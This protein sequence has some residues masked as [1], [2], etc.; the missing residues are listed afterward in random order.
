MTLRFSIIIPTRNRAA[1]LDKCL[2]ALNAVDYPHDAF[3]VLVVDD[4]SDSP[5][6]D[7]IE[8]H[9]GA[10]RMH[11]LRTEGVGPATARNLALRRA[12]GEYVV[13]TDDDTQAHAGWLRAYDA[14]AKA[15]PMAGFGG[16][17]VDAPENNLPERTSQMLV[18]FL[19]DYNETTDALR[20]FCSNNLVFPRQALMALGGFD[21]SFPLA[22][23]EDRYV[24]TRW[25]RQA[26]LEFV[27]DA[28]ISHRQKLGLRGFIRQQF[29]YGR[30]ASQFWRRRFAEDGSVNRVQPFHFYSQLMTYPFG[31]EPFPRAVAMSVLLFCS[32][33]AGAAGYYSE[34]SRQRRA[35]AESGRTSSDA[36]G[37]AA[38]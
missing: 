34:Q 28:V 17:I 13:F 22:A 33:V 16:A 30:G 32:Q 36:T 25:L 21:E 2:S 4:G 5:M 31:R 14:A 8:R 23:G 24:C 10:M 38:L 15:H 1:M 12:A 29:R 26:P 11:G 20:F 3:E 7:V 27:R 6:A 37:K 18:S 19:Y 35:D 9:A